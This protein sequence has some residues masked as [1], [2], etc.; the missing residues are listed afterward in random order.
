MQ[1]ALD[2]LAGARSGHRPKKRSP[3]KW[4][5]CGSI[6]SAGADLRGISIGSLDAPVNDGVTD[7]RNLVSYI[8]DTTSDSPAMI[9][10]RSELQKL[11]RRKVK[12][13][14]GPERLVLDLYYR[15]GLNIREIAPILNLHITRVSQIKAQAVL[16]LR[17][18][19]ER[20]S[21]DAAG[22]ILTCR[23]ST[24]PLQACEMCSLAKELQAVIAGTFGNHLFCSPLSDSGGAGALRFH[25][26]VL[27]PELRPVKPHSSGSF[28]GD[29]GDV[30]RG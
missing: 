18:Y 25:L 6:K 12:K 1:T 15:Q 29:L 4:D 16:R 17:N 28:P 20:R 13:L 23:R 3:R 27:W 14:P 8:A 26:V 24:H 22:S 5:S 30:I 10:E 7:S 2:T 19:I 21:P 9:L 11:I